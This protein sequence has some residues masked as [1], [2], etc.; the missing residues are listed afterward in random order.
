MSAHVNEGIFTWIQPAAG[1]VC[2]LDGWSFT[3]FSSTALDRTQEF[4]KDILEEP[5]CV[6][7][8]VCTY[9]CIATTILDMISAPHASHTLNLQLNTP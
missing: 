2:F 8:V 4:Y 6:G 7:S 9:R 3:S 5:G 1:R